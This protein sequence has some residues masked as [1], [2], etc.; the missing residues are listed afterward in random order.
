MYRT[1]TSS[2]TATLH[3]TTLKASTIT[4]TVPKAVT[5]TITSTSY[6]P[7][8]VVYTSTSTIT[9]TTTVTQTAPSTVI[10]TTNTVTIVA[11]SATVYAACQ[12]NNFL[13]VGPGGPNYGV[14]LSANVYSTTFLKTDSAYDC[15]VACATTTNCGGTEYYPPDNSCELAITNSCV[16]AQPVQQYF[17]APSDGLP[18]FTISNGMRTRFS[19]ALMMTNSLSSI[20]GFDLADA[21]CRKLWYL[22]VWG[23]ALLLLLSDRWTE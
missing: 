13:S 22:V 11:P 19:F 20:M 7:T 15:C 3:T 4:T 1:S 17:E 10:P 23:R 12:A 5:S 6:Y 18:G 8:G 21:R 14:L 2:V 16:P 9:I